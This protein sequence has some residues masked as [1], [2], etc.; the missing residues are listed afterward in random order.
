MLY[1]IGLPALAWVAKLWHGDGPIQGSPLRWLYSA[2]MHGVCLPGILAAAAFV[3]NV[4]QGRLLQ[5]G[6]LSQLLPL[7]S[8]LV[9]FGLLRRLADP[10]QIPGFQRVTGF[11]ALLL[12]TGLALFLLLRTRIWIFFGGGIEALLALAVALFLLFKWALGRTFGPGRW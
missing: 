11:M 9:C 7:L 2:V 10:E 5:V 3:D 4:A 6:V 1:F 12:L 8:M